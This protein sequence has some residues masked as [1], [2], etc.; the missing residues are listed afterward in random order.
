[1]NRQSSFVKIAKYIANIDLSFVR[2]LEARF[3]KKNN[4]EP[5]T[6]FILGLPRSGSTLT[7]QCFI[8]AFEVT[9]LSNF[10]HFLYQLPFLGNKISSILSKRYQSNF[11]SD[12]GY[13]SGFLGPAEGLHFWKKWMGAD[14]IQSNNIKVTA[15][16]TDYIKNVLTSITSV[17]KPFITCYLGH[18]LKIEELKRDFPN[19]LFIMLKRDEVENSLSLLRCR[20][21]LDNPKSWFSVKPT[22]CQNLGEQNEY[23]QIVKQ[24]KSLT[25]KLETVA[26]DENTFTVD[27]EEICNDPNL[28]MDNFKLFAKKKGYDLSSKYRLPESFINKSNPDTDDAITFRGYFREYE[29]K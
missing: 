28:V 24:V 25:R 15:R 1:M 20:Q 27:F 26:L 18:L 17:K 4:E 22:D 6:I 2:T 13:V 19:A 3:I 10:S 11:H 14:I 23:K 29:G 5:F 21:K 9:Y 8:N 16:D 12:E 7:Y